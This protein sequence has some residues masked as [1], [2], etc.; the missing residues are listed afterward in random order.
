MPQIM[1]TRIEA[2]EEWR[3][4]PDW[5]GY[6]ISDR[7]RVRSRKHPSRAIRRHWEVDYSRPPRILRSD[8][9]NGYPS[10]LLIK[11]G[12]I[13]KWFSLHRLVLIVFVGEPDTGQQA[14]HFNGK[15][16]DNR[17]ANLRWASILENDADKDRHGTRLSGEHIGTSKL[18]ASIV[19]II[20]ARYASGVKVK[21]LAAQYGVCRNTI[22]N[23]THYHWWKG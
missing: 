12:K 9:R 4:I 15:K 10:V 22:T 2:S 11:D 7:G 5:D 16:T 17:L 14:A 8:I 3:P 21:D 18:T 1:A 20:R 23:V 19:D 6:E 13:R